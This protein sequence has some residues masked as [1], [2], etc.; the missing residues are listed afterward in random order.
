MCILLIT[1]FH[2][3]L[4]LCGGDSLSR[5]ERRFVF[6]NHV[7][8]LLRPCLLDWDKLRTSG[9]TSAGKGG[10]GRCSGEL[11]GIHKGGNGAK[12]LTLKSN[13]GTFHHMTDIPQAELGMAFSPTS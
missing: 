7:Y 13:A 9:F 4:Q 1:A 11:F 2:L 6:I 8:M 3:C 10:R 12:S 5:F